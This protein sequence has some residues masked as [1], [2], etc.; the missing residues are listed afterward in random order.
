MHASTFIEAKNNVGNMAHPCSRGL[1][2]A[3]Q[4]HSL[5]NCTLFEL[6]NIY[7]CVTF[8]RLNRSGVKVVVAI[9]GKM[10]LIELENVRFLLKDKSQ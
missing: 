5:P 1:Q 4:Q 6:T 8:F 9:L 2:V 10:Y 3:H 7:Q